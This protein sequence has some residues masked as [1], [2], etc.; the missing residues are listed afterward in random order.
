MTPPR[1][2]PLVLIIMGVA[3]SLAAQDYIPPREDLPPGRSDYS[4]YVDR[5]EAN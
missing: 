5:R 4:P 1:I 3:S 2:S